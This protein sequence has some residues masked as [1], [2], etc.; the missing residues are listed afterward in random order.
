[1]MTAIRRLVKEHVRFGCFVLL[2]TGTHA[3]YYTMDINRDSDRFTGNFGDWW[4]RFTYVF[5]LDAG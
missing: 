2:I 5:V 1:M 3:V 4:T